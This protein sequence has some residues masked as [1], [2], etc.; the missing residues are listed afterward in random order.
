MSTV[1]I[2]L[3]PSFSFLLSSSFFP[4]QELVSGLKRVPQTYN[5]LCLFPAPS[6]PFSSLFLSFPACCLSLP[7]SLQTGAHCLAAWEE[8]SQL[9]RSGEEP[10]LDPG[11]GW[12]CYTLVTQWLTKYREK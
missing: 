12:A 2:P 1:P 10:N 8:K 9:S 5:S 11:P 7:P 4:W 6:S 3:S